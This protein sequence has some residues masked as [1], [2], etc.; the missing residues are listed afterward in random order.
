MKN[1]KFWLVQI[2]MVAIVS[3]IFGSPVF[4]GPSAKGES[5]RQDNANM[6]QGKADWKNNTVQVVVEE[7]ACDDGYEGEY[8]DC[9]P[10]VVEEPPAEECIPSFINPCY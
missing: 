10:I 1:V 6:D 9:T 8:P 7:V 5:M 2:A 3:M 4:A